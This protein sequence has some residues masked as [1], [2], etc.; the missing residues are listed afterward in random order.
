[1]RFTSL[2]LLASGASATFLRFPIVL[3][4]AVVA[5]ASAI[6]L[7]EDSDSALPLRILLTSQLGIPLFFALSIFTESHRWSRPKHVPLLLG[8][9]AAL[10]AY[11]A[12]LPEWV[13]PAAAIRYTQF[14][15]GLHLLVAFLPFAGTN[16]ING[17]WQ[18]NKNLFLRF[19]TA[20][21]YSGV[22]YVGLSVA[23]AAI[24][25]L[26]GVDI[27]GESYLRLWIVIA[28]VFNTWFFLGG[29][30]KDLPALEDVKDYPKGL[31]VFTQ[32]ILLPL[33]AVYLVILTLY[34]GKIVVT[35]VWPSGWIGYLVSSVA[36]AGILAMLLVHPVKDETGN[37][38]VRTFS[39]WFYILLSPS[40][41]MLLLAIWKRIDQY[42][43]TELRYL[44]LLLALW[45]A[46]ISIYFVFSRG[47]NI[48]AI[49]ASLCVIAF[50]TA[51]GPWGA[52]PVSQRSQTGRLQNLL[53]ESGLL[54]DGRIGRATE[55]V[56]FD[57]RKEITAILTYLIENQSTRGI[58]P[59]FGEAFADLDTLQQSREP[60][61]RSTVPRVR[62]LM[63]HMGLEY[64]SKWQSLESGNFYFNIEHRDR[65]Y[66]ID[67]ADYY[68]KLSRTVD[69]HHIIPEPGDTHTVAFDPDRSSFYI[70]RDGE[71]VIELTLAPLFEQVAGHKQASPNATNFPP[72]VMR[73]EGEND[74]ARMFIY[75]NSISGN[76]EG[77]RR[78]ARHFDA[79][80]FIKLK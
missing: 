16:Q 25:K 63:T 33:I 19:L 43:F 8:G 65:T 6:A 29:V 24:D 20:V 44:L 23:L 14:N 55:E 5:A 79:D 77:E 32:Y 72:D 17:F 28:A 21:L 70:R 35:R 40:I 31:K 7:V 2:R 64:V 50:A 57:D 10:A 56:P 37:K 66:S 54:A 60:W 58:E 41:V 61:G 59:W 53:A 52:S 75:F 74:R 13:T 49:P 69:S 42:G 68:V 26:L 80:C 3:A 46:A 76:I 34:L 73:I 39:R 67:G 78:S 1:M 18:Y 51:Y 71:T 22:L 45:L 48:K 4:T 62:A 38:W 9:L 27:E 36:T 30:P 15:A 11:Y 12:L 47:R